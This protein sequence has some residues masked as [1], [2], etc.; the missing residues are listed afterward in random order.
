MLYFDHCR[1][2]V[3]R[4]RTEKSLVGERSSTKSIFCKMDSQKHFCILDHFFCNTKQS[5]VQKLNNKL[6][7]SDF[8]TL[9]RNTR[10]DP[11]EV[12][13][14]RVLPTG[15]SRESN[16]STVSISAFRFRSVNFV[17]SERWHLFK[18]QW[19]RLLN[20]IDDCER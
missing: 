16:P 5:N 4:H 1:Q 10:K 12:L 13:H 6:K 19:K 15:P 14:N 7:V 9:Q 20:L 18:S 17:T 3:N 2:V 11:S 8:V